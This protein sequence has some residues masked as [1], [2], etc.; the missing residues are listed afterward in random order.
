M[1]NELSNYFADQMAKTII[2]RHHILKRI[3]FD[4]FKWLKTCASEFL[5]FLKSD[6]DCDASY[7]VLKYYRGQFLNLCSRLAVS[8]QLLPLFCQHHNHD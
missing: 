8:E 1:K 5:L 2:N 3:N 4:G 7:T 6:L